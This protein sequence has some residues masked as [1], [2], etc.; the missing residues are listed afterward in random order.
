M[1]TD[2]NGKSVVIAVVIAEDH[3]ILR[4]GLRALISS[5]STFD[6]VAEARDGQEAINCVDKFKPSRNNSLPSTFIS[7]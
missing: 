1:A 7:L 4:E 5:N 3:T 2:K 6:V